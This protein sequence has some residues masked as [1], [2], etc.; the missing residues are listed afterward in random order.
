M[1]IIN[2][3]FR[4]VIICGGGRKKRREGGRSMGLGKD[5]QETSV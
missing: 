3:K 1:G 5:I 4:I 2:I